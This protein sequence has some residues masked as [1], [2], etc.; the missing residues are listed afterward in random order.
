MMM[1][2]ERQKVIILGSTGSIGQMT[3]EVIQQFPDQ[4]EIVGLAAGS[5]A[6][7]L[8]EQAITFR[9]KAVSLYREEKSS[10]LHKEFS[11]LGL[12]LL[13]GPEAADKL[14]EEF[15]A[16]IVVAAI[17]GIESL[18][19]TLIA[20]RQAKRVALASKE[21]LVVAGNLI[22]EEAKRRGTEI[23]PVDSEHCGVFQCLRKEKK[24]DISRV[25][26]TASGGPFFETPIAELAYKSVEEALA[27]PRWKMGKKITIDSATMMNKGLELIEARWLFDLK[28]Q[29]LA[30][31]V[32]P[33][34]IVH[35][36]VELID[37]SVLAQLSVTD[38]RLPI[39]FALCYPK[40]VTRFLPSLNLSEIRRL[41]FFEV[42]EER[43][44]LIRLAFQALEKGG[45]FPVALNAANEVA[46]SS[47][48]EGKIAFPEISK[49]VKAVMDEH[50][51]R[52]AETLEEILEIDR[53]TREKTIKLI[54]LGL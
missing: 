36:L 8:L 45:S 30:V 50:D 54:N 17:P 16:D 10:T 6:S 53:E 9:P 19:P 41:E 46:V 38:M 33:Q 15:K 1:V 7:L 22:M 24:E 40:R 12:K 32:H 18:K 42:D 35:S 51:F 31:L 47:F 48:I 21:A 13:T 49:I 34:S 26:L 4:F 3:L 2:G 43:F 20:V 52:P 27:H 11:S 5:N 28:P 25:I 14:V 23:I 39:Q 29:Q 37:G 44:P